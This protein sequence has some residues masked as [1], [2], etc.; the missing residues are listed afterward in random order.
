M[1]GG[2]CGAV[3]QPALAERHTVCALH[4]VLHKALALFPVHPVEVTR[5]TSL[6]LIQWMGLGTDFFT[7]YNI[8]IPVTGNTVYCLGF[9]SDCGM[10]VYTP[11]ELLFCFAVAARAIDLG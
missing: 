3:R 4:E 8:V 11:V 5:A 10:G 6:G 7:L 9:S 2:A 1:A